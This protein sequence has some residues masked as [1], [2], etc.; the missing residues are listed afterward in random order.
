MDWLHLTGMRFHARHGVHDFERE[1]GRTVRVDVALAYDTSRAGRSDELRDTIDFDLVY[2][3]VRDVVEKTSR[4]LAE[5]VAED[6]ATQLLANTPARAV[7]VHF[8]KPNPPIADAPIDEE[9]VEIER[10]R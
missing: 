2:R 9:S 6:V 8:R 1:L 7:R 4:H 5:R 3:T 10:S